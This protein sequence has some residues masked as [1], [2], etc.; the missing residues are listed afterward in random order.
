MQSHDVQD[1]LETPHGPVRRPC[2]IDT[3]NLAQP[4]E[5]L[6]PEVFAWIAIHLNRPL[7]TLEQLE[8]LNQRLNPTMG[9]PEG[10]GV[11]VAMALGAIRAL[12]RRPAS[13]FDGYVEAFVRHRS[14]LQ[15]RGHGGA[16]AR[17][18][19]LHAELGG[20]LVN[21]HMAPFLL[22]CP[23]PDGTWITLS[24]ESVMQ[25]SQSPLRGT[26]SRHALMRSFVDSASRAHAAGT[27]GDRA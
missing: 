4:L 15:M 21:G 10:F 12:E 17:V 3:V 9:T 2:L 26:H 27:E 19:S 11:D 5:K 16:L 22:I 24:L 25:F 23:Q 14:I 8:R 7:Y 1:A 20:I 6:V 13:G 18:R